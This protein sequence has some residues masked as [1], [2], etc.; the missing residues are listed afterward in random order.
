[1]HHALDVVGRGDDVGG[2]QGQREAAA[3]AVGRLQEGAEA[4]LQAFLKEFFAP[5][6]HPRCQDLQALTGLPDDEVVRAVQG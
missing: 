2:G 6:L 5:I 1:M 3:V 4:V